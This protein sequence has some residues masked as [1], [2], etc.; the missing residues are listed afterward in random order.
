MALSFEQAYNLAKSDS[1]IGKPL[2][3]AEGLGNLADTIRQSLENKR[4]QKGNYGKEMQKILDNDG[5]LSSADKDYARELVSGNNY[6]QFVN[7]DSNEQK[8]ALDKVSNWQKQ[9]GDY[10]NIMYDFASAERYGGLSN[11]FLDSAKGKELMSLAD[12]SEHRLE[13]MEDG[14]SMGIRLTDFDLISET[15]SNIANIENEIVDLEALISEGSDP[16]DNRFQS[17]LDSLY[18]QRDQFQDLLNAGP[19]RLYNLQEF[20]SMIMK[21][22]TNSR[23]VLIQAAKMQ[24]QEGYNNSP[25]DNIAFNYDKN[26]EFVN[27][28]LIQ[29]GDFNSLTTDEIMPGRIFKNDFIQMIQGRTG[30]TG[31]MVRGT[32]YS[33][34]GITPEMLDGADKNLDDE[35]D[36][37]EATVIYN[38]MIGNKEMSR[39]YLSNYFVTFLENNF[40]Q[41]GR[42]RGGSDVKENND[43]EDENKLRNT[44]AGGEE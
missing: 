39:Q 28:T 37:G 35:I 13:L 42:D 43:N 4:K 33:D 8:K 9:Y 2:A 19:T 16:D 11:H 10:T 26:Y 23:D 7:G 17:D 1:S 15:E 18:A 32:T 25:E 34:L 38:A 24:K 31:T 41:G 6:E 40:N 27:N 20:E 22:D 36:E 21:K 14:E 12:D 44:F 3:T 30:G 29:N 5:A